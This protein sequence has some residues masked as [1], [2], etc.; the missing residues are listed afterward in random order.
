MMDRIEAARQRASE[1]H[2]EIV[3]KGGDPTKPY[4]FVLLAAKEKDDLEVRA[5]AP[6]H[7]Q[8]KGGRALLDEI[9]GVILHEETGDAFLNAFLVAHELGHA[10]FGGHTEISPVADIDPARSADPSSIGAERVV[11]YSNQARQEVQMDLYAREFLLPRALAREWHL[12][13]GVTAEGIARRLGA[14]YDMVAVQLFD[15]L[16]LPS[17]EKD[18]RAPSLP[19]PLNPEQKNAAEQDG[20]AF[21]LKAGPGTGKTQTLVG[22]L[23]VL[24]TRS[25]D[26]ESILLVTFSNKAAGEITDRALAVWPEAAGAAWIGTFH[27]FGLDILRRFHD[28]AGFR[29]TPVLIDTTEAIALLEDEFPRLGLKHFAD[30]W[31]PTEKLRDILSA[32]SRA[33]DE[34]VD[35]LQYR[36]FAQAMLKPD[37]SDEEK[38]EAEKCLEIA[39]VYDLYESLKAERNLIDFGDL[40]LRPTMLLEADEAVRSQLQQRYRHILVDEY[41]D[42]N[43]ASVRLLKALKPDGRDLWVVGDGK[44]SIY[45]FR[46]ASSFNIANFESDFTNGI[47]RQLTRNY[48][49]HQ[50]ICDAFVAFSADMKAAEK[51]FK[52]NAERGKSGVRPIFVAVDTKEDEIDEAAARIL[53]TKYDGVAFKDQA[54]LCKGNDR[55][56]E[57]A[58]GLEARGIPI[59]FLGPLFDRLEVKRA[60]SLMSLVVDPRAMGLA[61]LASMERFKVG[62][63]DVGNAVAALAATHDLQP[64]DWLSMLS[65]LPTLS[66]QGRAAISDLASLFDGIE[67]G[68]T[69]W[70]LL[71]TLYLDRTRLAADL[72]L[73]A[74]DG[75]SNPALAIWQLQNF[76]RAAKPDRSGHPIS[77]LLKYIRRLVIL[78]DER[79]L[80]DLPLAAQQLDAVRLLTMHGAKGLEFEAVHLPSLTG[81]SLPRSAKQSPGLSPPD[82]MIA[83]ETHRGIEARTAGHDAEQECLF[84]VALSRSEKRLTLYSNSRQSD[85]KSQKRSPFIDRIAAYIDSEGPIFRAAATAH[86]DDRILLKPL[87]P[88]RISPSQ[89]AEFEKCPRRFFYAYV[90][91]LGGRRLESALM[92]MQNVVRAIVDELLSRTEAN[93]EGSEYE[94]IVQAAWEEHGP[95]EHGYADVYKKLAVELAQHFATMRST[96]TRR[97][98]STTLLPF[99]ALQVLVVAH[100]EVIA[101]DG[102]IL[103]RV[104]TG[105]KTS[106][107]TTSLDAAA[108]QLA[109]QGSAAEFVFLT[110]QTRDRIALQPKALQARREKIEKAGTDILAGRFPA[111]AGDRCPR[112]PY[113]F[114]CTPIPA[115]ELSKKVGV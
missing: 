66:E 67:P 40:V 17:V 106:T 41:Q 25:V 28:R 19:K 5:L 37:I 107:A 91:E 4:E 56:A 64:L 12:K 45:R 57:V 49:S 52:A 47:S 105:R 114:H 2:T 55:L 90:L 43:R 51:D 110:G 103:R 20:R 83:G 115:G 46:G 108:F 70:R 98:V 11:D 61:C 18:T 77:S 60:L 9:T 109:A 7:V 94:A 32:I 104:R 71:S 35:A 22:R 33:K 73:A 34:V 84:F 113:F 50:E 89:L 88:I 79:D 86:G 26:P 87:G 76:I 1:F 62:L 24:K 80:R 97:P 95:T 10:E 21:L 102:V 85:G 58:R 30:L 36:A 101:D 53:K 96:E 68:V 100:E 59:L 8:L 63:G 23:E 74:R 48:R 27:S 44:Q 29:A 78:S 69:P 99:G 13:D 82:G 6:K 93:P 14:P 16:L 42:V 15:A 81:G 72:C 38:V 39:A 65:D 92:Q 31:D 54:V 111:K 3:G 75:D 112:C